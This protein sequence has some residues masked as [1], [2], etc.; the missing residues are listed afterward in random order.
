MRRLLAKFALSLGA[1]MFLSFAGTTAYADGIVFAGPDP[2]FPGGVGRGCGSDRAPHILSIQRSGGTSVEEGGVRANSTTGAQ[3]TF[4]SAADDTQRGRN[5]R[6]ISLTEIGI[7]H[8]SQASQLRLYFDINENNQRAVT[9]ETMTI[10]AYN[11]SGQMVFS[12]SL[13]NAPLT[14]EQLGQGQGHSDYVFML[15]DAA[16]ARLAAAIAADP[17]LRVGLFA[18]ISDVQG[19]PESFFLGRQQGPEPI[20]EPATMILLGTGL[21]GVAG[22]AR[23]RR[24]AARKNSEAQGSE[25]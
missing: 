18:R 13:L 14:L 4:G 20:P 10:A 3:E 19:G 22:A 11:A 6:L 24:R 12:A 7:T 16:A 1:L 23:R 25:T 9:L 2:C 5:T 8:A 17:N 21:A 15:D